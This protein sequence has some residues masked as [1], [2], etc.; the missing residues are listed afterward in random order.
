M[1]PAKVDVRI[2]TRD[3]KDWL[4]VEYSSRGK[5]P[6]CFKQTLGFLDAKDHRHTIEPSVSEP[7]HGKRIPDLTAAKPSQQLQMNRLSIW[8]Q[9]STEAGPDNLPATQFL[10]LVTTDGTRCY[11]DSIDMITGQKDGTRRVEFENY[12]DL[13]RQIAEECLDN[14][15]AIYGL[16][17][18]ERSGREAICLEFHRDRSPDLRKVFFCKADFASIETYRHQLF[19]D[20]GMK[21]NAATGR[22]NYDRIIEEYEKTQLPSDVATRDSHLSLVQWAGGSNVTLAIVLTDVVG[23]TALGQDLGDEEMGRILGAHFEQ[24]RRFIEE[25]NGREIKTTGDGLMVAFRNAGDA[26]D[27]ARALHGAPGHVK[28]RIRAGI[29]I[30]P[31]GLE[32]DDARGGTVS[33]AARVVKKIDGAEIWLSDQAKRNIDQ[34][35]ARHHKGLEWK[36]R[37]GVKMKGF[38]GE[39]KLWVLAL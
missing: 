2:E 23:S 18:L 4:L 31:V 37:E 28:I 21:G 1:T 38:E 5:L 35:G 34:R 26:L 11:A 20:Y 29:H 10:F 8:G 13:K 17:V 25:H 19:C 27:F 33:F 12:E 39:S 7:H 16:R 9:M 36:A 22:I 24:G 30:G 3:G 15:N 14:R 6:V 32:S